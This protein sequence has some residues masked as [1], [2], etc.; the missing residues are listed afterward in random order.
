MHGQHTS[1]FPSVRMCVHTDTLVDAWS[2]H[3]SW[4][5]SVR[6]CVHTDTLADAY[7]NRLTAEF[8]SLVAFSLEHFIVIV[9]VRVTGSPS[10][11][12]LRHTVEENSSVFP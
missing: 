6:M 5:P 9:Y 11:N 12:V 4:F 7:S 1:W 3:T 2:A 10:S 8:A